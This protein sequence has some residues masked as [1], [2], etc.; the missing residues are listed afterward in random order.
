MSI[1]SNNH[2]LAG[3]LSIIARSSAAI[4]I[5]ETQT[6]ASRS[7]EQIIKDDINAIKRRE[8]E[9]LQLFGGR[10]GLQARI[11]QFKKDA[12]NFRGKGLGLNFTWSYKGAYNKAD[13]ELQE[14]FEKYVIGFIRDGLGQD[15]SKLTTEDLAKILNLKEI[16]TGNIEAILNFNTGN[17]QVRSGGQFKTAGMKQVT[18]DQV[19]VSKLTESARKRIYNELIPM[20]EKEYSVDLQPKDSIGPNEFDINPGINWAKYTM[21]ANGK[22]M[23][24]TE[25]KKRFP[26]KSSGE[27]TEIQ[28][29]IK[30]QIKSGL[31]LTGPSL[32]AFDIVINHMLAQ[33]PYMFFVGGNSNQITGLIG[34]ICAMILFYDLI[35]HY[36]SVSWAAQNT[37]LSGTQDS[38]DI[39]INDGFG[40]QVKNSTQE[41]DTY[42]RFS[43]QLTIGF[44]EVS[45]DR[46]GT[47]LGFDG[48]TLQD[49]Y[50]TINYNVSYTWGASNSQG[51][52]AG[53]FSSGGNAAFDEVENELENLKDRFE[54]I[55]TAFSSALLYMEDARNSGIDFTSQGQGNVL[56]MVNLV[57]YYASDM[58]QEIVNKMDSLDSNAKNPLSFSAVSGESSKKIY[59][60]IN[61]DPAAFYGGGFGTIDTKTKLKT[62]FTF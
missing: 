8:E 55:M 30:N 1:S 38:A 39:I 21:G 49:L 57:P 9:L 2:S 11:A 24:E 54:H 36:P 58:L 29:Q 35:G 19:I 20:L 41:L 42:K 23:T 16:T 6:F 4:N 56:Y 12:D 5:F 47:K 33:N 7:R 18:L 27:L 31:G 13:R 46:L 50:D 32:A 60:E 26:N 28:N 44:S 15:I 14:K 17:V 61:P 45:F 59:E 51:S 25:A 53:T 62:S 40:I 48:N 3:V 22:P 10:S 52:K 37:G 43:N 34:E